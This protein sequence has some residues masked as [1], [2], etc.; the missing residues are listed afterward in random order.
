MLGKL[1]SEVGAKHVGIE[2]VLQFCVAKHFLNSDVSSVEV[3]INSG[4]FNGHDVAV[5][6]GVFPVSVVVESSVEVVLPDFLVLANE[7]SFHEINCL[8]EVHRE[9]V[10][11]SLRI[12]IV[13]IEPVV[14]EFLDTLAVIRV[15]E[16][17]AP[18]DLEADVS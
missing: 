15:L 18:G 8:D 7:A 6:L 11:D 2:F 17:L 1:P 12:L 5:G 10:V 13:E 3:A 9:G 14:H 16:I 4:R